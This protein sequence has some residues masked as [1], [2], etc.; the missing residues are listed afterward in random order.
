M[1][2]PKREE[3]E[4]MNLERLKEYESELEIELRMVRER[5]R[6]MEPEGEK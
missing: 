1:G 3:L 2:E 5:I 4:D 6:D